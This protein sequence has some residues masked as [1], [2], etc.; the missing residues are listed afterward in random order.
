MTVGGF[1]TRSAAL[2]AVLLSSAAT[3]LSHEHHMDN[4]EEGQFVSDDP[5]VGGF[6]SRKC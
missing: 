4:I 6:Q 5:I 3:V 2:G 1:Q